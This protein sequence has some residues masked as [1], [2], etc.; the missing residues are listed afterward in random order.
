VAEHPT[1]DFDGKWEHGRVDA[2]DFV[3]EVYA[4]LVTK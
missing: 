2:D 1:S 3:R 4:A